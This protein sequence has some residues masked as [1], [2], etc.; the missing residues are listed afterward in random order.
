MTDKKEEKKVQLL[1]IA[2]HVEFESQKGM[3]RVAFYTS[4]LD[5][6]LLPNHIMKLSEVVLDSDTAMQVSESLAKHAQRG[7][8]EAQANVVALPPHLL[9]K[10][11][12]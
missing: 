5:K 2:D 10:K 11:T 7:K 6:T 8:V 3:V 1:P 9:P 4:R 12:N